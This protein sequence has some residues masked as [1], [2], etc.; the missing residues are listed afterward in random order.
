M[1]P[2]PNNPKV[3]F[4]TAKEA[5]KIDKNNVAYF[6]LTDGTVAMVKKDDEINTNNN[7]NNQNNQTKINLNSNYSIQK[8]KNSYPNNDNINI[9]MGNINEK[10][11]YQIIE[12]IPVKFCENPQIKNYSQ[13]EPLYVEPYLNPNISEVEYYEDD[14]IHGNNNYVN[15]RNIALNQRKNY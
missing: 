7:N 11:G 6:T 5:E 2:N 15:N 14:Y 9:N 10:S 3:R 4:I 1:N 13:P 8:I 12:A